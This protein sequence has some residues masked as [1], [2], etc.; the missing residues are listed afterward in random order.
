ML[1]SQRVPAAQSRAPSNKMSWLVRI[2]A[3]AVAFTTVSASC[4]DDGD[5]ARTV[6]TTTTVS[7]ETSTSAAEDNDSVDVPTTTTEAATTTTEQPSGDFDPNA[8]ILK[9]EDLPAGWSEMP[10]DTESEDEE[11]DDCFDEAYREAG[12]DA[13]AFDQSG[14]PLA[15]SDFSQSMTGPFLSAVV[16]Q[17]E[18]ADEIFELLPDAFAACDGDIDSDGATSSILPVN[19]PVLGDDT[20]A[21]R[22]DV[23][24]E[25]F[26]ISAL[27][28]AAR[29][30]DIVVIALNGGFGGTDAALVEASLQTML[31]RL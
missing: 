31:D 9:L 1:D 26:P 30:G 12:L 11:S 10:P 20:F 15:E 28:A 19:F 13:D 5:L 2:V 18:D 8:V 17:L 23:T 4:G 6:E 25:F 14:A 22:I 3:V 29:K 27:F 7:Q 21:V 24:T 16:T